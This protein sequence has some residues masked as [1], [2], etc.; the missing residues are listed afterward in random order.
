MVSNRSNTVRVAMVTANA[1]PLMGGIETH[2][3]EVATRLGAAG[4]DVTVLTTDRSGDLPAHEDQPG[5][6]LSRWRA[7]PDSPDFFLAPGLVRHLLSE[8]YDV[9]HM[10]GV[11]TLVA[12][13]ALAAARRARIPSVLTFHT[14]G[15]SSRLRGS[16]RPVQW[17]LLSPLLRSAAALV[18][19]SEY[20]RRT[21]AA[22]LGTPSESTIRLIRNGSD[23]LPVDPFAAKPAGSPLLLSV[24]R[25]ERYKGHHRIVRAMPAILAKAPDARLILVGEGPYERPLRELASELGVADQVSIRSFGPERRAVMGKLV[26]DADVLCLLS[27]YEA[28]PVAVMEGVGA[29][30][31][32]LVA[33]TSGLTELGTTGLA[34]TIALHASAEQLAAAVL[35]VAAASPPAPPDLP[36]WD[37]CAESLQSLYR[38]VAA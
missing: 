30:T 3:H 36:S 17:R 10:Q 33:D 19:V 28:H 27:E 24:G 37:A 34:T 23:P 2:V 12:P 11:H 20:E 21:F 25:L 13:T 29:G 9:V 6:R 4:V 14:G 16:L 7:Y 8:H 15:H 18:A 38:E 31:K 26:A 1:L 22:V 5:Y 35:G 32:V